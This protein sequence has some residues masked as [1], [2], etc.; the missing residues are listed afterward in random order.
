MPKCKDDEGDKPHKR[1]FRSKR[2][3]TGMRLVLIR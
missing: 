2:A 3:P 1:V